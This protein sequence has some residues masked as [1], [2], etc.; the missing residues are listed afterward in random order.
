[1]YTI[2]VQAMCHSTLGL[3][4]SYIY[5]LKTS[6]YI[7]I[8]LL[9]FIRNKPVLLWCSRT[10]QLKISDVF[11]MNICP[12]QN[13]GSQNNYYVSRQ[14]H[15]KWMWISITTDYSNSSYSSQTATASGKHNTT[16]CDQ[17]GNISESTFSNQ[18]TNLKAIKNADA[19]GKPQ[20]L[21]S[22]LEYLIKLF[23]NFWELQQKSSYLYNTK[24][25]K[26][27]IHSGSDLARQYWGIKKHNSLSHSP[28]PLLL[29]L[30]IEISCN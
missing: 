7:P 28:T 20:D 22:N 5:I 4:K 17:T 6:I 2:C 11:I 8:L 19:E 18:E 3:L 14:Q 13:G 9:L 25:Y 29:Y 21:C 10:N 1:M 27:E 16:T 30:P 24:G 23:N 15:Y 12:C 26:Q